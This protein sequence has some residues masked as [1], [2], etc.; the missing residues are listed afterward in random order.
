[1]IH[2]LCFSVSNTDE[3]VAVLIMSKDKTTDVVTV[4]ASDYVAPYRDWCFK[5]TELND[6]KA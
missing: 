2:E 1:M 5:I 4:L 3:G 6:E